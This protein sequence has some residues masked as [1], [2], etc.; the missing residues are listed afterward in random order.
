VLDYIERMTRDDFLPSASLAMLE[1]RA[2]LLRNLRE[3]FHDRGFLEVETPMLSADVVVDRHLEPMETTLEPAGGGASRR[4]FLQTSPEFAMKRLLAGGAAA[5]YQVTHAFR[6]GEIG[7]LHNPEFTMVEWYR[8][9]DGFDQGMQLLS[10]VAEVLL[11][12][13]PAERISYAAAFRRYAAV[14]AHRANV[15]AL[16][17]VLHAKNI[18]VPESFDADDRDGLLDLLLVELVEPHLG[19]GRPTILFDYP[20]SQ[21]AL[22]RVRDEKPAVAE[23]FE[24][25]ADGM[26]L[27]NGYHEL[28]DPAVLRERN[29][30]SNVLRE[31]DGKSR[32]PEESR[33]LAAMD[34]AL[35]PSA[36]CALGF[37]RC[38]MLA[39]GAQ[40]IAEVLPFPIDRA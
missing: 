22:A 26:E 40:T 27:A 36:G 8:R 20:P 6:Q 31:H 10:D 30:A 2:R 3:F 16:R 28:L 24:L 34:H 13:G 18:S 12:R 4:L 19:R 15:A 21:A 35:P 7:R 17:D 38:V 1:L 23:R 33:L 29:R 25:Y 5:I 11:A 32:L 37:D 39:S 9:D 14:D